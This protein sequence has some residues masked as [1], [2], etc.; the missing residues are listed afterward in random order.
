MSEAREDHLFIDPQERVQAVD[1]LTASWA[2][3]GV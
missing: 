3:K 2:T 1:L